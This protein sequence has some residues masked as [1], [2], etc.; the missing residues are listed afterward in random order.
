MRYMN[1]RVVL[2]DRSSNTIVLSVLLRPTVLQSVGNECLLY[3]ID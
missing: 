3:I 1:V 2:N